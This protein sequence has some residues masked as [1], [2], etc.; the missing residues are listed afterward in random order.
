MLRTYLSDDKRVR[1]HV[2]H[3]EAAVPDVTDKHT[4]PWGFLSTVV[5][6]VVHDQP[7]WEVTRRPKPWPGEL[8]GVGC[9]DDSYSYFECPFEAATC[10]KHRYQFDRGEPFMR[11]RIVCGPGGGMAGA[12]EL[13]LLEAGSARTFN[14]GDIYTKEPNDIHTSTPENGTVTI[15]ERS[16]GDDVD[17]AFVYYPEGGE[18]VSAEPRVATDDEVAFITGYALERWYV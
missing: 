2:W 15:I 12:P 17:H 14:P 1:L 9:S 18:W 6:G 10:I 5:A 4:H 11:Q 3:S 13:V 7:F 16:F 8:C